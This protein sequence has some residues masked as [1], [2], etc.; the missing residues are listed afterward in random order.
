MGFIGH[1]TN[2]CSSEPPGL[3]SFVSTLYQTV[4]FFFQEQK[5]MGNVLHNSK[6]HFFSIIFK[7]VSSDFHM[8]EAD[9]IHTQYLYS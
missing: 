8:Q 5:D 2:I 3:K 1:D 6:G 9:N 4:P 7:E